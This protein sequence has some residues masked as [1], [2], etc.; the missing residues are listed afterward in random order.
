MRGGGERKG[1]REEEVK[2]SGV[3]SSSSD[4]CEQDSEPARFS[5]NS[6]FVY[7]AF[8]PADSQTQCPHCRSVGS[9]QEDSMQSSTTP[10]S[11]A[12][13]SG[14]TSSDECLADSYCSRCYIGPCHNVY[15][16]S[17]F[18]DPPS[19]SADSQTQCPY[20]RSVES[21]QEDSVRSSAAPSSTGATSGFTSSD[22]CSADSYCSRCY[23]GPR[24]NMYR[25]PWPSRA[26]CYD[27]PS[28]RSASNCSR[29]GQPGAFC[30]CP[31]RN[32]RDSRELLAEMS[33]VIILA[34]GLMCGIALAR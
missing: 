19:E 2:S 24:H 17:H 4:D 34:L 16:R 26:A 6:R 13:T 20:C 7:P 11:T 28:Y 14:S 3:D 9:S 12:A 1:H 22:E 23:L 8:E 18:V 15:R 25:Y 31:R 27:G 30:V 10:S 29:C 32:R 5:R 21:S 33:P